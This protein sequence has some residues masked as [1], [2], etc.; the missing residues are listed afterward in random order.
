MPERLLKIFVM[1]TLSMPMMTM[2]Q[3]RAIEAET[4][5]LVFEVSNVPQAGA[6]AEQVRQALRG[7]SGAVVKLRAFVVG[8]ENV[9]PVRQAIEAEFKRRRQSMPLLSIIVIG[10]LPHANA[11]LVLEAVSTAGRTVN[12]GGI[13]FVSGQAASVNEGVAQVA[14][15]IEKSLAALRTAHESV[16]ANPEDV[17][18]ATCFVTSLTDFSEVRRMVSLEYPRAAL[19]FV[20]LQRTPARG[21]VECET[22]LRLRDAEKQSLR[23]FN[24]GGLTASPNYSHIALIGAEWIVF[25]DLSMAPG[26]A[27][28]DA[29]LAFSQLEQTLL[30]RGASIREV[31]MS[32]LYPIS[33]TGSD[34]I[35]N[36]RF[37]FYDKSRPPASTLLLFE[38]LPGGAAFGVE[39]VAP[40]SR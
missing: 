39:V 13:A 40:K 15:L 17:L 36:N 32:H 10:A 4:R 28:A 1:W 8:A 37:H 29:K 14:P 35:R 26:T 7:F 31:A 19:N 11:R 24:P 21:L 12:P 38:A 34:L 23:F 33:Q 6:V 20:Q 16:R 5:R 2:A 27:E 3:P 30:E 22:V 18:R 25:S 9:E